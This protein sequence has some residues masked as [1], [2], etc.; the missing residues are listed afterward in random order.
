MSEEGNKDTEFIEADYNMGISLENEGYLL[1]DEFQNMVIKN[2]VE[3]FKKKMKDDGCDSINRLITE[4]RQHA[5][6]GAPDSGKWL[7]VQ[8]AIERGI[9]KQKGGVGLKLV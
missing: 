1:S 4:V 2:Q 3:Y 9:R 6:P 5:R 7:I 8:N